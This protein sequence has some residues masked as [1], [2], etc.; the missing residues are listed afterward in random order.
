MWAE[1]KR[2]KPRKVKLLNKN[3]LV[4]GIAQFW[5]CITQE[6]CNKYI[7]HVYKVLPKVATKTTASQV[8]R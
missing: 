7:K 5:S 3:D 2:Y 6:K 1:V 4:S 8:N